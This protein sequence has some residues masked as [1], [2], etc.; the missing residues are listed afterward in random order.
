MVVLSFL[1]KVRDKASRLLP[2]DYMDV[3]EDATMPHLMEPRHESVMFLC[4]RVNNGIDTVVDVVRAIRRRI[5]DNDV[6]IQYLTVLLLNTLI[7]QCVIAFH[8]ELASQKGL[9]RDLQNIAV[10]YPCVTEREQLAKDA[11]LELILNLSI[12]F[13]GYPDERL[14]ILSCLS[15]DVREEAGANAFE[16]IQPDTSTQIEALKIRRQP[17]QRTGAQTQQQRS[18][19]QQRRRQQQQQQPTAPIV[20]A[21][22]VNFPTDENLATMVECCTTFAE[23][24]N[25]ANV[26]EDGSIEVDDI[27]R[28]FRKKISSDHAELAL[29]LG[30]DLKLPNRDVLNDIYNSQTAIF[31]RLE[32]SAKSDSPQTVPQQQSQQQKREEQLTGVVPMESQ[33]Q[34]PPVVI[35][36]PP[37]TE[38][39]A[40]IMPPVSKVETAAAE[41]EEKGGTDIMDDLFEAKDVG[42]ATAPSSHGT[43]EEVVEKS[44]EEETV[45]Q[46]EEQEQEEHQEVKQTQE[47]EKDKQPPAAEDDFDAFLEGRSA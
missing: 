36:T 19:Q 23:Y 26:K 3:V 33:P 45:Q 27:I 12:W 34:H 24:L 11:A 22:G 32:N 20:D 41:E 10:R 9:L 47:E 43:Q 29:L 31:Q 8:I 25:N 44:K 40:V 39:A 6:K 42:K 14:Y 18:Q 35:P 1:E 17:S 2:S 37:Q 21:I 30:S 46:E 28:E 15:D 7:R 4:D 5:A 16:N 38:T 13:T